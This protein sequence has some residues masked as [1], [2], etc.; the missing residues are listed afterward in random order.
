MREAIQK[1]LVRIERSENVRL[2]L[3]VESGSRAW[4]FEST[5]SDWDV[6]FV[7]VHRPD[8]YLSIRPRRDVLEFPISEGLDV[9]GWDL[10][11]ALRLFAKS[12]PPM[13][14][15][16]RSPIVYQEVFGAASRLRGLSTEF[17]APRSCLHHYLHMAVGNFRTYLQGERVRVKKYFYVLRPVLACLWI[18]HRVEFPPMEFQRLVEGELPDG[19]VRHRTL[20]LLERKR[21]GEELQEGPR[22]DELNDFLQ[23]TIEHVQELVAAQPLGPPPDLARLDGVFHE[24]LREAWPDDAAA[25]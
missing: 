19:P 21:R 13:L 25:T 8:W 14:E 10:P 22:I 17:F 20:E 2:L 3:A 24:A 11:K 23:D 16:L 18:E 6:R 9:S 4:G 7:Y 12:N 15:W 5:D 1:E